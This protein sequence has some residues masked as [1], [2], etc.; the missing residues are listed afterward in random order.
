V[1]GVKDVPF[2]VERPVRVL[3]LPWLLPARV[4]LSGAPALVGRDEKEHHS[5]MPADEVVARRL[6]LAV[7]APAT[8]PRN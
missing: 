7:G 3:D 2:N 1:L 6:P 4:H 8:S 5:P